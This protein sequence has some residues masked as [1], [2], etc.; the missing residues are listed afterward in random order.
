MKAN[1]CIELSLPLKAPGQFC[2][3]HSSYFHAV[4]I[5]VQVTTPIEI[6]SNYSTVCKWTVW[7]ESTEVLQLI[8][9]EKSDSIPLIHLFSF[10]FRSLLICPWIFSSN[11]GASMPSVSACTCTLQ[12][13]PRLARRLA[14]NDF[15]C[16]LG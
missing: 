9:T 12:P 3:L 15:L 2:H 13:R 4:Y 6:S 10:F 7:F 5:N 8:P 14:L 11:R 1:N 16:G